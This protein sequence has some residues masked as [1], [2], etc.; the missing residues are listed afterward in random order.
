MFPG[1]VAHCLEIDQQRLLIV[2][3][4]M[5]TF[6]RES[7]TKIKGT[8]LVWCFFFSKQIHTGKGKE[9]EEAIEQIDK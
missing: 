3:L 7:T 9:E 8:S 5:Q 1:E 4:E 6:Q 2:C